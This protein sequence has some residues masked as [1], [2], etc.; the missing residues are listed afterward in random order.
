MTHTRMT[1]TGRSATLLAV[2]Q[3]HDFAR[4]W[5]PTAVR[6][7][8]WDERNNPVTTMVRAIK[9]IAPPD[10]P[11]GFGVYS[12]VYSPD[13]KGGIEY[14]QA[15]LI[16]ERPEQAHNARGYCRQK[17]PGDDFVVC[18]LRHAR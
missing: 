6:E 8:I 4:L 2:Q 9:A 14:V 1:V 17:Q 18:E 16:F 13:H 10:E 3:F 5:V 15:G 7:N 11:V 12:R